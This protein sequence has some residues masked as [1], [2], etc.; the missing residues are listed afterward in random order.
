MS[1]NIKVKEYVQ[2]R[3]F[4][5]EEKHDIHQKGH[6]NRGRRNDEPQEW[7]PF[8]QMSQAV[9][10]PETCTVHTCDTNT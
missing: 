7:L 3:N 2:D 6:L 9:K 8:V 5:A 4:T 10:T 1:L